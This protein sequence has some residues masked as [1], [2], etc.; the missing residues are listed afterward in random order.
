MTERSLKPEHWTDE[1][2]IETLYGVGPG[3]A[4]REA[5][6]L[7]DCED[8]RNRLASM[9]LSRGRVLAQQVEEPSAEALLAQR[10]AIY[11][12]LEQRA[13]WRIILRFQKWAPAACAL[14]VLGGGIAAWEYRSDW[15]PQSQ[16]RAQRA[17]ISDEQ[18][19]EEASQIAN[20]VTPDAAEPLR[21]LFED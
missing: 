21:A 3:A 19:A 2:L 18:L 14:L 15:T 10:R 16:E 13:G 20:E 4:S 11:R 8:C 17:N 6:H 9:Q 12:R 5:A 1:Q 7:E